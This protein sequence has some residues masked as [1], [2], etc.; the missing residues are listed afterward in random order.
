MSPKDPPQI[1]IVDDKEAIRSLLTVI[2][3]LPLA[4]HTTPDLFLDLEG[5]NLSR[6]GT[7][8]IITLFI[9][10]EHRIY[11]IDVHILGNA[12][13][14]SPA[15]T[16]ISLKSI[17]ENPEIKKGIFDVRMD[18]DALFSHF[19]V[20]IDGV[21]DIQLMELGGRRGSK[22]CVSGL[23][24]C[25][26]KD[27]RI[28]PEKKVIWKR[29]KESMK[30]RFNFGIFDDRPLSPEVIEYCAQDVVFLPDLFIYYDSLLR[31][32]WRTRVLEATKERIEF[33]KSPHFPR[34]PRD[35]ALGPWRDDGSLLKKT[36]KRDLGVN[37]VLESGM[38][39]LN[40]DGRR[41]V[42]TSS[43]S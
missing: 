12:A 3:N 14:E 9:V 16:E 34:K 40:I 28:S 2:E 8:S 38:S 42:G 26:E 18:S 32:P 10:S 20:S 27:S 31:E 36:V 39:R 23:A 7:L 13:F 29:Q 6:W 4:G 15:G 33:S 5:N 11:L 24:K 19:N 17:L 25:I 41:T 30:P 22:R 35:F 21:E 43:S 37:S 1:K